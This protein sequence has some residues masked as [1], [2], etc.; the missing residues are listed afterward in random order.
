VSLPTALALLCAVI[1]GSAPLLA[2]VTK[3]PPSIVEL[4]RLTVEELMAI[5]VTSVSR[6]AER[7]ENAPAAISVVTSDDINRSGATTVPE[8]LRLVPGIHVARQ[9]SSA[10]AVSSRGFS[11][12]NSEKLLVLTDTRS[13]YTPCSPECS[14]TCRT[15]CSTTSNASR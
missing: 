1:L 2:Q 7:L 15:T 6:A 3:P 12:V 10:W 14:G 13:L 11:S 5:E 8:A 4:K 9:T